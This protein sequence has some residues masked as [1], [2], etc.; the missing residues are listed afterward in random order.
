[1]CQIQ[2]CYGKKHFGAHRMSPIPNSTSREQ[3]LKLWV[4]SLVGLT[5]EQKAIVV[6]A[7][8]Q[9]PELSIG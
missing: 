1:M 3:L 9:W 6:Q 7:I 2:A 8:S 5:T 4:E